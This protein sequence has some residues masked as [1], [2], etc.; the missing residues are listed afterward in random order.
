MYGIWYMEYVFPYPFG[1]L[2]YGMGKNWRDLQE[3]VSIGFTSNIDFGYRV[4]RV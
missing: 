3:R 2:I 1:Y 4:Y